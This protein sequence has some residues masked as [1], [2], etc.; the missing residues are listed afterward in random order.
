MEVEFGSKLKNKNKQTT[1]PI[2]PPKQPLAWNFTKGSQP[3]ASPIEV[4]YSHSAASQ[5]S[6]LM[7]DG[8]TQAYNFFRDICP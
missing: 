1:K 7:Q 8:C 4:T 3:A 5:C 2:K 6:L